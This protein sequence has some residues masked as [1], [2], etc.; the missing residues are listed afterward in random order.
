[1]MTIDWLDLIIRG[2]LG[3]VAAVG[4]A[5]LFNV[6]QRVLIHIY[7]L[8]F[9]GVFLKFMLKDMGTN[10]VLSS[11]VGATIIGLLSIQAAMSKHA[12]PLVFSIPAVIPMVPGLYT[13]RTMLGI[14]KLTNEVGD[15][16][17]QLM[18]ETVNNG[19]NASLIL[20]CLAVGVGLPNF[21]PG[22]N[23]IKEVKYLDGIRRKKS[24]S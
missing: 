24:K 16:Y 13:Y 5:I 17:S 19:L 12:P 8:G 4:F 21:L 6:P 3:G 18:T 10:I 22:K 2:L 15:N 7:A 20:M 14:L 23:S 9:I 11:L 1:M